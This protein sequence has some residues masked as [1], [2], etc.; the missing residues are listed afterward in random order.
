M[1]SIQEPLLTSRVIYSTKRAVAMRHLEYVGA[2]RDFRDLFTQT[3]YF[4]SE[5]ISIRYFQA[6]VC[7]TVLADDTV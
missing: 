2:E 1:S 5:I 3:T 4:I 7:R 6:L